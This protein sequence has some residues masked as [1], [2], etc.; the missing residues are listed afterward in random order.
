MAA[1]AKN[2]SFLI[3]LLLSSS[4][5]AIISSSWPPH[6]TFPFSSSPFEAAEAGEPRGKWTLLMKSIGI[7]A[8]HMQLLHDD[9]VIIFDRTDFGRSNLSLPGGKCRINDFAVGID[10][11][12]H[13]VLYDVATNTLRPLMV[14]TD[15]WCSSGS[16]GPDG[17]LVQTG[18]YRLGER[19]VRAFTPCDDDAC[20]WIEFP[21]YLA[22]RRWYAS[23][24][25]L[26]DGRVI[27]VGGRGSHSYEF[28]PKDPTLREAAVR[29][30]FLAET[31]DGQE[32]ENNLYPF[33]HL[34]PDG[35]LFIFANNRSIVLNYRRHRVIREFP[36]MP[37]RDRR[38]YPLTGSS[39]LL[40][41]VLSGDDK[42]EMPE[43]EVLICGGARLGSYE[44]AR[45]GNAFLEASKSCGRLKITHP[46]PEWMMEE[47]PMPRVMGDMILLPT[48]DVLIIN[49]AGNGTAGWDA[50]DNPVLNPVLYRT[51]EPDPAGRFIVMSPTNIPRM[52]HSAALL[53]AD[54]RILVGGS[55]PNEFYNFSGVRY[56]T[57]LS[58][59]SF[60]PHYLDPQYGA[61][62][63]AIQVIESE[64]NS[65][66]Y[67]QVLTVSY[68]LP[69]P[70]PEI[71]VTVTLLSP[72]FATHSFGM[73]QRLLVLKV[74]RLD[75]VSATA[76]KVTVRAPRNMNVGPPGY[77]LLFVVNVGVPSPGVW[78]RLKPNA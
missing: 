12:A 8:M 49:G 22:A 44:L 1:I 29:L 10:C 76:C 43:L 26:P 45:G 23:N 2:V 37:G 24:H 40:P 73:N 3:C 50:A 14:Q 59:E 51:N 17:T 20:D 57:E 69:M 7:S 70:S 30:R 46:N 61:Y 41:V 27:V 34:L 35:N 68:F 67:G 72:A 55:N 71:G 33:L 13:S 4:F 62:R 9:K 77:Y 74:E 36:V 6:S 47:M 16:V 28:F 78:V 58:L 25:I 66:T 75:K 63:P 11:T 42:V 52:Y 65:I 15:T 60:S 38:S 21:T 39:V 18:G 19:V 48:G 32:K 5:P 56:P 54:G 31:S 64:D 53:V